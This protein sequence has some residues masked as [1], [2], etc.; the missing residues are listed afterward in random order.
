MNIKKC[1]KGHFYN[2]DKYDSCPHCEEKQKKDNEINIKSVE[3]DE[4]KAYYVGMD[5]IAVFSEPEQLKENSGMNVEQV[6]LQKDM[7]M[8][9]QSQNIL[10]VGWLVAISGLEYGKQYPIFTGEN[11][12]GSN[13]KNSI[14]VQ[15]D[16][17][18]LPEHH[19]TLSFDMQQQKIMVD[20]QKSMGKIYIN[21]VFATENKY[22]KHR[23][24]IQ[25]GGSVYMLVELCRDGFSWWKAISASVQMSTKID[26]IDSAFSRDEKTYNHLNISDIREKMR[27]EH[28]VE[29]SLQKS[30]VLTE[31]NDREAKFR[32]NVHSSAL[33]IQ[34]EDMSDIQET[35]VLAAATWR[36]PMCNG[37]NS[38]FANVCMI[39][40]AAKK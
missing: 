29:F 10:P 36:C 21:D 5:T 3:N 38:E 34:Q 30:P 4:H 40:G 18:V 25:I 22:L 15:G 17:Y 19:C 27:S 32:R 13:E 20:I 6:K 26:D 11:Y 1:E 31:M 33:K 24:K 8:G 23:D 37:L 7:G 39:C 28:R 35:N 2:A 9:I 12:I 14:C 16:P